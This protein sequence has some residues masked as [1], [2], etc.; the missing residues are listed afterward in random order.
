M[1]EL[2]EDKMTNFVMPVVSIE[3]KP[4]GGV[5]YKRLLGSCFLVRGTAGIALTAHHVAAGLSV[6]SAAVLFVNALGIWQAVLVREVRTHPS[7]DV[8]VLVLE[9][10]HA[11]PSILALSR[12]ECYGTM[13]YML[14][15][16]PESVLHDEV[17]ND[18]AVERPDLVYDEGYIRR[19]ISWGLP[20][21]RGSR[22]FELSRISGAGCSGAPII[23]RRPVD[24]G[25]E[26]WKVIGVYVGE[27]RACD[28][29][30]GYA[31][32]IA[33]IDAD[34]PEW[35]GLFPSEV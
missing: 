18:R 15:G 1:L 12:E 35:S 20:A 11:F 23:S 5:G 24:A 29:T 28:I 9:P 6:G 4:D 13:P 33:D 34:A 8:A 22:F 16:Y 26:V 30:V 2:P 25:R 7:E 31:V 32:R 17:I 10:E 19:R 3:P 21:S 27:R 14:W